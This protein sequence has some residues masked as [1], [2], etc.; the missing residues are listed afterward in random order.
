MPPFMYEYV[1]ERERERERPATQQNPL[2]DRLAGRQ[3]NLYSGTCIYGNAAAS[4]RHA[5]VMGRMQLAGSG[6]EIEE[7]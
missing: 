5:A 2:I 6:E 3:G 7:E 4:W 1:D